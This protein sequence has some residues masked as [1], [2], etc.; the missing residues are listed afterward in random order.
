[1]SKRTMSARILSN[2][3]CRPHNG[4]TAI[5][6][7]STLLYGIRLA[8]SLCNFAIR[9]HQ[10]KKWRP[11]RKP[12]ESSACNILKLIRTGLRG[13]VKASH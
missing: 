5:I 10:W 3:L 9:L 6:N 1:M 12:K 8:V 4:E 2:D 11:F 13:N 7:L